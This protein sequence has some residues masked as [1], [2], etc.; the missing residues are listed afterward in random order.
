MAQKTNKSY[1]KRVKVTGS[2]KLVTRTP[3]KNHYNAKTT[4]G[5]LQSKKGTSEANLPNKVIINNLPHAKT[6]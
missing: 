6:K 4:R 5:D 3:G 1:S 2:G